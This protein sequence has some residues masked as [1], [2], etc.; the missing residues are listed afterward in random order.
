MK[1]SRFT[2]DQIIGILK[3]HEARVSVADPCRKRGV[4]DAAGV[5]TLIGLRLRVH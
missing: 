1:R 3:A 5:V 2:E 4:S